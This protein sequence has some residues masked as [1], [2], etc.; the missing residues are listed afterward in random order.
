M[1]RDRIRKGVRSLG[2]RVVGRVLG[3]DGS[4][5]PPA[6]SVAV[7]APTAGPATAPVRPAPEPVRA[8]PEPVQAAPEAAPAD[9]TA[10]APLTRE[11]VEVLF[12]DMVRPALQADGGDIDLVKVE[13]NDVYV[14]L[15]GACRSC[16]SSTI[17][18]K[19]GIERLL[20]EEFPHFRSLVQVDA[21]PSADGVSEVHQSGS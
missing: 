17:T 1:L 8:A 7:S 18:M 10:G 3:R 15:V 4:P 14:R 11:A 5:I 20:A 2:R 19:M 16:P 12:A 21:V 13:D 9:D 6:A